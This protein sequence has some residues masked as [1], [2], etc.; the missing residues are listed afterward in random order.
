MG[1][2]PGQRF[3]RYAIEELVG[4]GGMGRVY[5]AFDTRLQRR[6]ALKVLHPSGGE[7]AEAVAVALR[8]ARAAAAIAHPN[9]TAIYDAHE[10]DGTA[11]IVMEFVAGTSLR[12][13]IGGLGT[14][15]SS[16]PLATRLRWLIDV[17][18]ALGAAHRMGVVHRDVKPENVM[19]RNDGLVKVLDFG[20]ARRTLLEVPP[21]ADEPA[22][23]RRPPG[24]DGAYS[25]GAR[26]AGTPAY[27]APEQIRG[28]EL[29]GRADQFGWGVLAY[30]LLTGRLPWRTAKDVISYIAAVL[31][32]DPAPPGS[33]DPQIPH[34]V[35]AVVLR[36]LTKNAAGRFPSMAA[37]AVELTP[38]ARGSLTMQAVDVLAITRGLPPSP[39]AAT[40]VVPERGSDPG[41]AREGATVQTLGEA[42]PVASPRPRAPA[43]PPPSSP[44]APF[45]EARLRAAR[46]RPSTPPGPEGVPSS[47]RGR[48]AI[49][50]E[51]L[52]RSLPRAP[53]SAPER[54]I[55]A[56]PAPAAAPGVLHAPDFESPVDVDGHLALIPPEATCKGF[57]FI[58]ILHHVSRVAFERDVVR[59]AQ[60]QERRYVAFRDY[61]LADA[62]RLVVAAA[63]VLYPRYALGEG[64]RRL[65]QT[66]FDAVLATHVGRSLFGILG[67]DVEPILLT[68]P[69]A[70]KVLVNMGQVMAEKTSPRTF[71]FRAEGFP[72]FLET[73]QVG[74]L[75]GVLRN[76]GEHARVRI[77]VHTLAQATLELSLL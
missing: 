40:F 26:I 23:A 27:M 39:S 44:H 57:F 71:T 15:E 67:R 17:A 45:S 19:V 55:L 54:R 7:A 28:D 52:G 6:V 24:T 25:S 20:V 14:P 58:D 21:V 51:P 8:E 41:S 4:E 75:E 77:A 37:A 32:E 64:L 38:F 69:K 11:F 50:D 31:T 72:G 18:A 61:P 65:G 68:G 66:T 49:H 16:P 47:G 10:V 59:A 73:L 63:R 56:P 1:V 74:V 53:G 43:D 2:L 5:R 76:C 60:I 62:T 13:L 48:P 9:A 3:D 34:A 35:G 42:A 33:I 46:G 30:E 22:S 36:A 29:D 12:A 70:F